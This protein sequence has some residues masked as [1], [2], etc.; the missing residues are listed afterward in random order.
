MRPFLLS[1]EFNLTPD[2]VD[3]LPYDKVMKM[4]GY[5]HRNPSVNMVGPLLL[6]QIALFTS[7][8]EDYDLGDFAWWLKDQITEQKEQKRRKEE[9]EALYLSMQDN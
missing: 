9:M 5:L 1:R 6:S 7:Q 2:Q 3:A 4:L 8:N